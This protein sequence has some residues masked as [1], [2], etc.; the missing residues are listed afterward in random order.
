MSYMFNPQTV[1]IQGD[2]SRSDVVVLYELCLGKSVVEFGMGGSTLLISQIAKEFTSYETDQKWFDKTKGRLDLIDKSCKPD[3]KM[4]Y[5]VPDTIPT[6]DVLFIDGLGDHR[7]KWAK[8]LTSCDK[9][10]FHDSLGDTGTVPTVHHMLSELLLTLDRVGWLDTIQFHYKDS[11][12]VVINKRKEFIKFA[13][14]NSE[15]GRKP[16]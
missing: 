7:L 5:E 11:N 15:P 8:F 10:L 16:A 12:I 6:C 9:M 2:I 1:E 4:I 14:W 13:N 3:L